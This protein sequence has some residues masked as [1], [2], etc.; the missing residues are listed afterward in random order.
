MQLV[1]VVSHSSAVGSD[2]LS[3]GLSISRQ[4]QGIAREAEASLLLLLQA[5]KRKI[6]H[7]GYAQ[8]RQPTWTLGPLLAC[9]LNPSAQ[10][11]DQH[12]N[13]Q[14]DIQR[15]RLPRTYWIDSR[16]DSS[17]LHFSSHSGNALLTSAAWHLCHSFS[18]HVYRQRPSH[19][20]SPCRAR[21]CIRQYVYFLYF[22]VST[23]SNYL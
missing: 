20:L 13:Y 4:Q 15:A 10:S 8:S 2:H 16:L 22:S 17:K 19:I 7:N 9:P 18:S 14:A 6:Q 5:C 11:P 1:E 3:P 12:T 23:F 21:A